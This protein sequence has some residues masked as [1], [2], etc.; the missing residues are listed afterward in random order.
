VLAATSTAV[1]GTTTPGASVAIETD[2][3]TTGAPSSVATAVAGPD[4]SFSATVPIGF[5]SNAITVTAATGHGQSTGYAQVTVS[6]EGG[7][8]TVLDVP[9]AAGDGVGDDNGPGTYQYP[10]DPSFVPGA[11]KLTR[12]QVLSDGTYA[13]VRATI[14]NLTP[15]FGAVD[16]A[17]LL[18]VYVHVPGATNTSTQAAYATRNYTIA[19]SGAWSQRIEV[20]GFA[21]PVWVDASGNTVGTPYVL[22]EQSDGTITIA[23]PEA[24]FGT[25]GPGWGFTAVLTGQDGFSPDQA[26]AFTATPGQFTFGVCA[27]GGTQPIC[28]VDPSTV[29]KAM[30]VITPPGVSQ[31]TELNPIP[32]PVAIQP[33]TVP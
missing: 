31:Q 29:P 28:S 10:T 6:N 14:A 1:T 27:A 11:F 23:L 32:G 24:Q 18:D 21:S 8:S 2:D 3:S 33:V 5:G 17:Q 30:D 4:G 16:G 25:P 9:D 26:R 12:F 19:S 15:T 7:G 13:Y 22:A 20:Q